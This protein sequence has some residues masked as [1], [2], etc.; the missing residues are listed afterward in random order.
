MEMKRLAIGL[1]LLLSAF[2][3]ACYW[4]YDTLSEEAKGKLEVVDALVGRVR[5]FPAIYYTKRIELARPKAESGDFDAFDNLAVAYSRLGKQDEAIK[6]IRAKRAA[7]LKFPDRVD[8]GVRYRTES[9]EGTFWLVK[10]LSASPDEAEVKWLETGREMI[11]RAIEIDP[12]AHFG[13]EKVQLDYMDWCMKRSPE[14]GFG[15]TLAER[16]DFR[17]DVAVQAKVQEGLVGLV[18]LGAAW[19]N[20][21]II[22]AIATRPMYSDGGPKKTDTTFVNLANLRIS[23]LTGKPVPRFPDEGPWAVTEWMSGETENIKVNFSRLRENAKEFQINFDRFVQKR[24]QQGFHPDKDGDRFWDG[25]TPVGRVAF[26]DPPFR[27]SAHPEVA[28]A[29]IG[30]ILLAIVVAILFTIWKCL[31][32]LRDPRGR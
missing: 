28:V 18:M 17:K 2:A 27:L 14:K 31:M 11:A 24:V 19:E 21:D 9:N 30:A 7:M 5:R 13:R 23:E 12:N 16:E 8:D 15:S 32:A 4:D 25:Y 26:V 1:F 22:G 20:P 6:W 10:Y 3:A 29:T